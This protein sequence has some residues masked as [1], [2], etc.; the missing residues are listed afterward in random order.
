VY[1]HDGTPPGFN[2]PVPLIDGIVATCGV[3]PDA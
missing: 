2:R 1:Q 3:A